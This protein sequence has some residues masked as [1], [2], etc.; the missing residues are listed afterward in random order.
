M[1]ALAELDRLYVDAELEGGDLTPIAA[2]RDE[3]SALI[4][5]E[6]RTVDGLR[7]SL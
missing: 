2:V 4:D 7:G 1:I 6:N 5:A 3:V